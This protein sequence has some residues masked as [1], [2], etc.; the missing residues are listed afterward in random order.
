[1]PLEQELESIYA[2]LNSRTEEDFLASRG[3]Y[4]AA[5]LMAELLGFAFVDAAEWLRFDYDGQVR[6]AESYALLASLADGRKI[7]TPGFYGT[8]PDGRIHTFPRGG[9]DVTGALAAA[10]LRADV[11]ENWTDVPGVLTADPRIV[12][13]AEP[14]PT[15]SFEELGQLSRVGTQV[16]HESAVEPVR[17]RHIPLQIRSTFRPDLPGTLIR[18]RHDG[19]SGI[20]GFAGRRR[21]AMLRIHGAPPGAPV[22][23]VGDARANDRAVGHGQRRRNGHAGRASA[24]AAAGGGGHAAGESCGA[25]GDLPHVGRHPAR[26]AGGRIC[27]CADTPSAALRAGAA[28]DRQRQSVRNRASFS[29]CFEVTLAGKQ[30]NPHPK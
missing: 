8:L 23:P 13:E 27:R 4:L 6:E 24:R 22:L 21:M 5:R 2:S 11:Y 1:M 18:T 28:D 12:P 29:Q 26:A 7:V 15:L 14:I 9:S 17:V 20:A 3:E 19:A 10:A 16:L 30:E 25:R